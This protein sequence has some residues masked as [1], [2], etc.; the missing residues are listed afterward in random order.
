VD[1]K[2]KGT[3][4][5]ITMDQF[6]NGIEVILQANPGMQAEKESLLAW[7][8]IVSDMPYD[9]FAAAIFDILRNE[10]KPPFGVNL[11]AMI[12]EKAQALSC[13]RMLSAEEAWGLVLSQVKKAGV[14]GSPCFSDEAITEAVQ[15]IGWREICLSEEGNAALRAHFYRTYEKV[16]LSGLQ[17]SIRSVGAET[18]AADIL[19]RLIRGNCGESILSASRSNLIR[20]REEKK[21]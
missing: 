7:H 3:L 4:L 10:K 13:S 12:R 21:R 6:I 9:L 14:Y 5:A 19:N 1:S 15:T 18:E 2:N 8:A 16:R 11:G 20:I 17:K